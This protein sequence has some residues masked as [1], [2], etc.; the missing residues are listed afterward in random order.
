MEEGSCRA[1]K[2]GT[3][4]CDPAPPR[5]SPRSVTSRALAG[6][7]ALTQRVELSLALAETL[8]IRRVDEEDDAVDLGE[9]VA[10]ETAGL[11]VS[12][13][14]V[15]RE[16]DVADRELLRRRVER[17]LERREAVVLEHVEE[18]L[19]LVCAEEIWEGWR[20]R[21]EDGRY[22]RAMLTCEWRGRR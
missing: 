17:G 13:E 6:L 16:A 15:G 9:V 4:T 10:P 18:G 3:E 12:A 19:A 8:D 1:E 2:R 22:T 7:A 14:V 20:R 5:R 21:G 11:H